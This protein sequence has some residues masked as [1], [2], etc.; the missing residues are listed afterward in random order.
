MKNLY[1]ILMVSFFCIMDMAACKP[2]V[3]GRKIDQT[4]VKN[5]DLRRYFGLW[6]EIGRYQNSFEKDLVGVTATYTSKENGKVEV[7]NQGFFKELNGKLKSA[8]G[9]AKL[10]GQ[11][12]KLKVSFFLNFYAE[13]NVLEL[14]QQDYQWALIG[15]SSAGYLWILSRI[16][17]MKEDLY[18]DILRKAEAR[19]Y[20][21]TKIFKVPQS[22]LVKAVN[23]L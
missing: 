10:T 12:G 15:S 20:D 18:R 14:D 17:V 11:T 13:Y 3:N 4:T 9:K 8:K 6:Y 2:A 23:Q 1:L 7:L 21:T 19:G 5:F 22:P 16:P